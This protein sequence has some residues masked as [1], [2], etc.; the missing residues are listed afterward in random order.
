MTIIETTV[1]RAKAPRKAATGTR[2]RKKAEAPEMPA[3]DSGADAAP[4]EDAPTP[5][6]TPEAS[7]LP[8]ELNGN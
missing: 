5:A 3:M 1:K 6:P 7:S 2:S 8:E 4:M